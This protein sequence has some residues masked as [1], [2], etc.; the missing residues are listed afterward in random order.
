MHPDR[1]C[2]L[3]PCCV[4]CPFAYCR[5]DNM[6]GSPVGADEKVVINPGLAKVRRDIVTLFYI[7]EKTVEEIAVEVGRSKRSVH[8]NLQEAR[9]HALT[10]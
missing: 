4:R 3:A 7:Q 8:R 5:Y 9:R 6:P 10:T 2:D 1:G